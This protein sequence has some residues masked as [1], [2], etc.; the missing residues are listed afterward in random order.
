MHL[1]IIQSIDS[2]PAAAVPTGVDVWTIAFVA[3]AGLIIG[4]VAGAALLR[5]GLTGMVQRAREEASRS[6][7]QAEAEAKSLEQ[8]ARASGEQAAL[9]LREQV[10]A[11]LAS[12]RDELKQAQHRLQRR[13]D[14]LE[15]RLEKFVAQQEAIESA[16]GK[17][18]ADRKKL[19]ERAQAVEARDQEI[20]RALERVSD[21][22]V[23]A[24]RDLIL[25]RVEE[26]ARDASAALRRSIVEQAQTDAK[27]ESR[28]IT[29]MAMQRFAAEHVAES[30]VRS[31]RIQSEDMK[32]RV[33]GREG[34]NIR[35]IE[36]AT[37]ADVLV[38]DTPGII[39]VSCFDPIRRTIAGESLQK[40]VDDGRVQPSRIE[41]IVESV[42]ASVEERIVEKGDEAIVEC[43]IRGLSKPLVEAL[44]KLHFRTSYGQN[45]LR[46]S[47]EVACLSQVIADCLGL[48]GA[49][50]RRCGLLHDIGKALDHEVEG[51]H[52]AIGMEFC[53]RNG[54]K[55]EAV[56][57]AVGGHHGDIPATSPYTPIVMAADALSGAR[58]GA[59]RESMEQ[60]VQRLRQLEA[61]ATEL[62]E[63]EEAYA[64]Q[65]GREVRVIVDSR[66]CSDDRAF[67][68]AERIAA[69]VEQEMT[70][71]G[72]V[73]VTV[74]RETRA[75]ATAR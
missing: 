67:D 41:E 72:E 19:Q 36:R 70:F 9:A 16:R 21:M 57:N 71:P 45:V 31:V 42:R 14:A 74:L 48:D 44:G 11:R 60:Y 27:K 65:A 26:E 62:D 22:T 4:G 5:W 39:S 61:L 18:E 58:P 2:L 59:R 53:R 64:V 47:V 28:E 63:V 54:E 68:I 46:H 20:T 24:A 38:D 34:R 8:A 23:E 69:R 29:L 1:R 52:P 66:R 35:A 17:V 43:G 32:G 55:D 37:G 7:K 49:L 40:L 30:T 3:L 15:G 50:A 33:I 12:D 6:L 13:E 73:K 56:L 75:E 51:G 10:E 25:E